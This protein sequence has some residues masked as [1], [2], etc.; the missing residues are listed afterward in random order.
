[1]SCNA[2]SAEEVADRWLP[3]LVHAALGNEASVCALGWKT[4]DAEQI[5]SL[6]LVMK[7][8]IYSSGGFPLAS[9]QVVGHTQVMSMSPRECKH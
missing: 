6:C 7:H 1:M 2:S 8:E 4:Q 9:S 3:T 5:G